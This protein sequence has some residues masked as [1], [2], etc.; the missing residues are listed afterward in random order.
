MKLSCFADLVMPVARSADGVAGPGQVSES[1]R[2]RRL[3]RMTKH[4]S[5]RT[6]QLEDDLDRSLCDLPPPW[7]PAPAEASDS[8]AY[9]SVL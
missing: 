6:G 5:H 8:H 7:L 9:G 3:H 1:R 2:R 4:R